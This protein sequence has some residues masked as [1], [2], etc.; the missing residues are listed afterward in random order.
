MALK[1]TITRN[2][3]G[4]SLVFNEAYHQIITI[5]GDKDNIAAFLNIYDNNLKQNLIEQKGFSFKPDV[6]ETAFN[7]IKQGYEYLKILDE[8]KDATNC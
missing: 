8:Y 4:Q 2:I 7:F 6:S 1:K 5:N 3:Y